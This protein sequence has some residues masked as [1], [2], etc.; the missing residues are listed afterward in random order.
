MRGQ[1]NMMHECKDTLILQTAGFIVSALIFAPLSIFADIF[2]TPAP[3]PS[4][5]IDT[6]AITN[7][8]VN[9]MGPNICTFKLSLNLNAQ[10]NNNLEVAFGQDVDCNGFLDRSE[11]DLSVG[12]D[13]GCWFYQNRRT[14]DAEFVQRDVGRNQLDC[15]LTLN[16]RHEPLELYAKDRSELVFHATM[17]NSLFKVNWNLARV[18]VRGLGESD[19]SIKMK[20][21]G[22][23]LSIR[24]Q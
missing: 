14:G 23:G 22:T 19:G 1:C 16:Y 24:I 18:V 6:E 10:T 17:S 21:S 3:A 9:L 7:V 15:S 2:D 13:S 12:W 11:I 8:A 4:S 5:M 20:T